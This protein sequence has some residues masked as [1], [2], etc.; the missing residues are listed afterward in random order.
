M[1]VSRAVGLMA[2][3]AADR[4]F[5][6]PRRGHPVS[7]FGHVAGALERRLWADRRLHGVVYTVVMVG[8]AAAIGR[9]LDAKSAHRPVVTTAVTAAA[10][11]IVL[12]GRSLRNEALGVA[13][14]LERDDLRAARLQVARLV[15]RDT[16]NLDESEVARA[17]IESLAE[18][19]SDAVV[20]PL[21]F[22]TLAGPAGLLGY[23]AVNTLD[24]M[25]GHRSTRY[26]AFGWAS[27]RID[28][29]ANLPGARLTAAWA[30][31]LA[32]AVEGSPH[33][34]IRTWR[35]DGPR[36][37]SPN[38]GPVEA[39]FAGA[40]RVRLGGTNVYGTESDDRGF[41]GDGPPPTAADVRRAARLADL[42]GY[43]AIVAAAGLAVATDRRPIVRQR[44]RT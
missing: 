17:A 10:T 28:D 13:E 36:H 31:L 26:R 15:G 39:A 24:A 7:G 21:V 19:T 27:A 1:S 38:A 41:L 37:P 20:A 18:N 30:T 32:P 8:S 11:W 14:C 42:V 34:A 16:T 22:G 3:F 25:V 2:G 35:S 9:L 23:R 4:V 12:G 43:G 6:D 5:G 29:I 40:L 44:R 33:E